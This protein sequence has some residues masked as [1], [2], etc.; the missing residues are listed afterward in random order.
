MCRR[1]QEIQ[2]VKQTVSKGKKAAP[3]RPA[4]NNR[5]VRK[6]AKAKTRTGS[7]QFEVIGML[8][9]PQGITIPV[10]VVNQILTYW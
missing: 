3:V 7:K 2:M 4:N 9:R 8:S 1:K 5:G 10:P 6:S